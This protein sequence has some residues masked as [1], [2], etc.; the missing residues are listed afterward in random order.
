MAKNTTINALKD[1]AYAKIVHK[2]LLEK[3]LKFTN[4]NALAMC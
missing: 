4:L 1:Y 3:N 2:H